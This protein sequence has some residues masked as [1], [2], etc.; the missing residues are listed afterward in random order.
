MLGTIAP[1]GMLVLAGL[2]I[3]GCPFSTDP[4]P[5]YEVTLTMLAQGFTSPV[6]IAV[7]RDGTKR[8]FI[9]DQIGLVWILDAQGKLAEA[10]FL[11][12][13]SR[14]V[15]LSP[16][17]D[18][19][20]LLG[21]AFHP[22]YAKNGRFYVM[23]NAPKSDDVPAGYDSELHISQFEVSESDPNIANPNSELTLLRVP[24]PQANNNG[25]TLIF[26]P[27]GFLLISIGDGGG[28]GDLG[29]GHT[30]QIGNAQDKSNLLGKIL[31]IDVNRGDPYEIPT[32]NPFVDTPDATPEIWAYGFRNPYRLSCDTGGTRRLFVADIGENL[33][34]EV[35]IVTKGGNYG[36]NV[37]E[38][39]LCFNPTSPS[40]PPSTC[41]QVGA[42]K[43]PLTA[44]II[45]YPHTGA[46]ISGQAVIG[47][48]VYRGTTIPDM[49]GLYV[50]GDF[51]A[52]PQ[53]PDGRLFV[54]KAGEDGLW[55]V[56]ELGVANS[57]TGRLSRYLL[58]F[59]RDADNELYVLTRATPGP[60]G[61]TGAVYRMGP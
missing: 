54:A 42:D 32:D 25:G 26:C 16:D 41:A 38:G 60:T 10:P 59:G 5:N 19:R 40:V 48:Y 8:R 28:Q 43:K 53:T 23:Y 36:W 45:T 33:R 17:H 20:G 22:T 24:M 47:G 39:D 27:E 55:K 1:W 37:R 12:I 34:Q 11:D 30:P 7:P 52:T 3:S 46:A 49:Q 29:D 2:A 4:S 50:F 31:R 57:V 9:V 61:T 56:H 13:R 58:G 18:E 51:S 6:T 35:D 14:L 44:P 15:S 21:M